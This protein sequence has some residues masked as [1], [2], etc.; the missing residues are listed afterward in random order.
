MAGFN[1]R[2]LGCLIALGAFAVPVQADFVTINFDAFT[3]VDQFSRDYGPVVSLNGFTFTTTNPIPG[4]DSTFT[5]LG[6]LNPAYPGRTSLFYRSGINPGIPG[7]ITLTATDGGPFD[8]ASIDLIELPG[9]GKDGK[10]LDL[11]P[12]NVSFTG[13]R[14]DGGTVVQTFAITQ[15]FTFKTLKFDG[16]T[17][18]SSVVWHQGIGAGN[19]Y[20][21]GNQTHQ[22]TNVVV[23]SVPVPPSIVL[24]GI[25][26]IGLVGYGWRRSRTA[27]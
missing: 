8:L 11:G 4:L 6:T 14:A 24:V 27:S 20:G 22:F 17:D 19:V 12:F 7:K 3:H 23:Q 21:T 13:N 16:F 1:V 25:G 26:A 15:F 10:P 2:V 5:S 18:L 9:I